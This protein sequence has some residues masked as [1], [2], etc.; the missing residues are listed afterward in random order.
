MADQDQR[1]PAFQ[2]QIDNRAIGLVR[3]TYAEAAQDAVD[4]GYAS[5]GT[6][7]QGRRTVFLNDA[8]GAAIKQGV[9]AS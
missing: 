5:W 6:D 7:R 4:A 2:F 3:D 9:R 8:L 1:P